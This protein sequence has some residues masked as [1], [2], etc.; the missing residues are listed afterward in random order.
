[1]QY[2]PRQGRRLVGLMEIILAL[3]V[4]STDLYT[5]DTADEPAQLATQSSFLQ[6]TLHPRLA[7]QVERSLFSLFV[8]ATDYRKPS[9]F[10]QWAI[11]PND[12][13]LPQSLQQIS[14]VHFRSSI[15]DVQRVFFLITSRK[16]RQ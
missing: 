1:M 8:A 11:I 3:L 16:A 6:N 4:V 9:T 14:A 10:R 5:N 15:E 2:V 7:S 12:R 13:L